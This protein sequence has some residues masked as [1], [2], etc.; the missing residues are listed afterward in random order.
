MPTIMAKTLSEEAWFLV[1][2]LDKVGKCLDEK[3]DS[4]ILYMFS[5]IRQIPKAKA[6]LAAEP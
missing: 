5:R 1:L 2:T 3:R 4:K 6:D